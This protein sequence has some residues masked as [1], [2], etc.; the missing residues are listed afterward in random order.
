MKRSF[1]STIRRWFWLPA[2][3]L[4]PI[5][6]NQRLTKQVE[7]S[8]QPK[9]KAAKSADEK[10]EALSELYYEV[11]QF[12]WEIHQIVTRK[13]LLEANRF[14]I[15]LED[16]PVPKGWDEHWITGA[17]GHRYLNRKSYDELTK[18]VR[19]AT[20]ANDKRRREVWEFRLKVVATVLTGLTGL[21]G[22]LIGLTALLRK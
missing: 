7:R 4:F 6:S 8:L 13:L 10:E 17:W 16:I 3:W 22:A 21:T 2:N 12:Q 20:Y 18:A 15:D 5:W 19:E 9:L 1:K 11:E 14:L